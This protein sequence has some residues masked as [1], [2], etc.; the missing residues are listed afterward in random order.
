MADTPG[1]KQLVLNL[2]HALNNPLTALL[3]EVQMLQMEAATD[4]E[5]ETADRLLQ[6]VNRMTETVRSLDGVRDRTK[7]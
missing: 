1:D 5:R 3:A 6:L 4:D 2:Q 7:P